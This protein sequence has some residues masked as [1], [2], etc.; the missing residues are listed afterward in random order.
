MKI[1][2]IS[3]AGKEPVYNMVVDE[4]HNYMIH[5]GIILKNCD[6]L[7]Y[8]CISRTMPT[9]APT[10]EYARDEFDDYEEDYEDAMTG[11]DATASYIAY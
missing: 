6:A 3:K 7:R 2:R 4:F 11:G 8:Y 10:E 9:L 1:S 5:G